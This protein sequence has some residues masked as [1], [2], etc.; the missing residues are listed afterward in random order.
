[1]IPVFTGMLYLDFN[2]IIQSVNIGSRPEYASGSPWLR[3]QDR[4]S[5]I[6]LPFEEFPGYR[7]LCL[8]P[9]FPHNCI[10]N[11]IHGNTSVQS[12]F[13]RIR[14]A[15][16]SHSSYILMVTCAT[17]CRSDNMPLRGCCRTSSSSSWPSTCPVDCTGL[18]LH[19]ALSQQEIAVPV[20]RPNIHR[21]SR[22]YHWFLSKMLSEQP[23]YFPFG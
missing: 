2:F 16:W 4:P 23:F 10:Q 3:I 11:S 9:P 12:S 6:L 8:A 14:G 20:L 22:L 13:G 21:Y 17:V 7:N 18:E 19:S 1:M 5:A 15:V